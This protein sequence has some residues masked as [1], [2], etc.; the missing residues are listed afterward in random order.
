[1]LRSIVEWLD[2]CQGI[3]AREECLNIFLANS[4]W[5]SN[6]A[7]IRHVDSMD[8]CY[9][10]LKVHKPFERELRTFIVG[11]WAVLA[12][13]KPMMLVKVEDWGNSV[14]AFHVRKFCPSC[15]RLSRFQS[16][17]LWEDRIPV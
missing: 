10:T 1:M 9:I 13:L 12:R 8:P 17:I 11:E 3:I 14:Q 2:S 16:S 5:R 15:R 4:M 6:L 7:F